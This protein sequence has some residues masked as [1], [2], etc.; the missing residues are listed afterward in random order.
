[1]CP[2]H[3]YNLRMFSVSNHFVSLHVLWISNPG[4]PTKT[5]KPSLTDAKMQNKKMTLMPVLICW[6]LDGA[7]IK[8]LYLN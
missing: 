4:K 7:T 6:T 1:M 8:V 5:S 2:R 3:I